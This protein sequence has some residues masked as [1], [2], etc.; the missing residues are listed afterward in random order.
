MSVRFNYKQQRGF[1]PGGF[2]LMEILITIVIL[3]FLS[4]ILIP[5]YT[6]ITHSPDPVIREKGIA[7]GQ[8]LMDEILSKKWD[9]NTPFGGGPLNTDLESSRGVIAATPIASLGL[10]AGELIGTDRSNWDD[11]D[12]YNGLFESPG[13]PVPLTDQ[14]NNLIPVSGYTRQ[15]QAGY[16]SST[17]DPIDRTTTFQG[18]GL[19]TTDTKLIKVTITMPNQETFTLVAVYCNI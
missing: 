6:S 18:P 14:S 4:L 13:T 8:A 17:I 9:E 15:V 10:D 3:G 12:D 16:I 11:V 5:F 1:F 2:S 19:N 7:L